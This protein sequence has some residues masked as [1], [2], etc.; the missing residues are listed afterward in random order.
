MIRS[1]QFKMNLYHATNDAIQLMGEGQLF[2]MQTDPN[3]VNNLWYN[4][5]YADVRRHLVQR[6]M[7]F[8]IQQEVRYCGQ[9]GGEALPSKWRS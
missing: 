3:E 9:R 2:D 5:N 1:D 6:M 8:L 7:A 4:A